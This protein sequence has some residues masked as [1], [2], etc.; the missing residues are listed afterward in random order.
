MVLKRVGIN[1]V[2]TGVGVTECA[3]CSSSDVN[4]TAHKIEDPA[5]DRAVGVVKISTAS[6][7]SMVCAFKV[8]AFLCS[9]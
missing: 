4:L 6:E 5:S 8:A 3:V 2:E 9:D 7:G 1:M